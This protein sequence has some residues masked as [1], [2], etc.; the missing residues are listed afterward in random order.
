MPTVLIDD[1]SLQKISKITESCGVVYS[2]MGPDSRVIVKKARKAAQ[3][4]YRV[5]GEVMPVSQLV[6]DI[7]SVMQEFTQSG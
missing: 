7:A 5:Y 2:G 4:Y 6:R 3:Q 1:E